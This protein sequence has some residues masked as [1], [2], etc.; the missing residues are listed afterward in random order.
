MDKAEFANGRANEAPLRAQQSGVP[1][2]PIWQSFI[3]ALDSAAGNPKHVDAIAA[4][5]DNYLKNK[6]LL[7][8][9]I[10]QFRAQGY[11]RHLMY[12]DPGGRFS[13]LGIVWPAGQHSPLHAHRTWCVFGVHS[14][15]VIQSV[16]RLPTVETGDLVDEGLEV[17]ELRPGEVCRDA[18]DGL[19]AHRMSNRSAGLAVSLHV[20]GVASTEIEEGINRIIAA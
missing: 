3:G 4:V 6:Q 9:F 16:G 14:G 8:G 15:A 17:Q 18:G 19:Y 20:Y 13:L 7:D 11:S 12:A 1:T 5:L 10:Y 2:S